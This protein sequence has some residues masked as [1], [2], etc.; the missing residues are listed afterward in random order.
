MS[1]IRLNLFR[2]YL[3]FGRSSLLSFW[4]RLE[5]SSISFVL[6]YR[7]INTKDRIFLLKYFLIQGVSSS[8]IIWSYF[9]GWNFIV[10]LAVLI[11]VGIAPFH[12][13]VIRI[14]KIITWDSWI[15][16]IVLQKIIPFFFIMNL[17]IPSIII[18]FI[19]VI[20]IIVACIISFHLRCLRSILFYS[21]LFNISWVLI[22]LLWKRLGLIILRLY[23]LIIA[24]IWRYLRSLNVF[25]LQ[26]LFL[27]NR[28]NY[29]FFQAFFHLIG[30]PPRLGF[31]IKWI[32]VMHVKFSVIIIIIILFIS[33]WIIYLY[34]SII[35]YRL[36]SFKA[37]RFV[38]SRDNSNY[39]VLNMVAMTSI[40]VILVFLI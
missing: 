24:P 38:R 15:I 1:I 32:V 23:C 36:F 35:L 26:Q 4:V 19:G 27:K 40:L 25:Y 13:W 3:A 33:L 2:I 12:I 34:T 28:R 9:I 11:K 39:R 22:R 8:I 31:L 37:T 21:S 6:I 5:L 30:F 14:I 10:L 20:N 18:Q 7:V 17:K 29:G 16:F